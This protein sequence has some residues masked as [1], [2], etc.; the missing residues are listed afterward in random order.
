MTAFR[1]PIA[2]VLLV[3]A[4]L[5]AIEIVRNDLEQALRLTSSLAF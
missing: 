4:V 3:V 2:L 1:H 5:L